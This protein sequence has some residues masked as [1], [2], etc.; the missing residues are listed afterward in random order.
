MYLIIISWTFLPVKQAVLTKNKKTGMMMVRKMLHI[1]LGGTSWNRNDS[2]KTTILL[3]VKIAV[4]RL[5]PSDTAPA[6][7]VQNAYA[8][9]TW[10]STPETGPIPAEE[11]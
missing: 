6:I 7:I 9:C 11:S 1:Q 8:L 4:W 3:F 5:S 2:R 10:M